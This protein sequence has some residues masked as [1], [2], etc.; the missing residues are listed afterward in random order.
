[1]VT[2]NNGF[3]L[4]VVAGAGMGANSAVVHG[5]LGPVPEACFGARFG[6]GFGAVAR[7]VFGGGA[8]AAIGG[9]SASGGSA[10][11]RTS[12]ALAEKVGG[13]MAEAG[14]GVEGATEKFCW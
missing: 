10:T 2:S 4:G 12:G 14:V 5:R 9:G 13:D 11:G 7:A 8:R 3:G 1:M 6:C